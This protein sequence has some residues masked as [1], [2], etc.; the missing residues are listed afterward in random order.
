MYVRLPTSNRGVPR[1]MNTN[2]TLAQQDDQPTSAEPSVAASTPE[3]Y[4]WAD[5]MAQYESLDPIIA[6]AELWF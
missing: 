3:E 4:P 6:E 5:E 1:D 2:P